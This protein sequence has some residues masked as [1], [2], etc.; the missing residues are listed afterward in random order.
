VQA[1][2]S[3]LRA[4]PMPLIRRSKGLISG[5]QV[6]GVIAARVVGKPVKLVL[7]REQMY[8]PVGHRALAGE[9]PAFNEAI[10]GRVRVIGDLMQ[11]GYQSYSTTFCGTFLHW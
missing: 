6:L 7:R 8:G 5:P 4:P 10:I 9:R 1:S 3:C 11:A 2:L